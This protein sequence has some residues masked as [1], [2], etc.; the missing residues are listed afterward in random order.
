MRAK[1]RR[2][3]RKHARRTNKIYYPLSGD[4]MS[5]KKAPKKANLNTSFSLGAVAA[6]SLVFGS[7]LAHAQSSVTLYGIADVGVEFLNNTTAGGSQ[8][9]EVSGNLSG[10]RWGLKG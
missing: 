7:N 5:L 3:I 6:A 2:R 9:R 10:S 1:H 4:T 8:V